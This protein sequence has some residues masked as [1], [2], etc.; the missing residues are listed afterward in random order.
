MSIGCW[1]VE[2]RP[3]QHLKSGFISST[4]FGPSLLRIGLDA[5]AK[6]VE[7]LAAEKHHCV[8]DFDDLISQSCGEW[9]YV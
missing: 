9:R 6:I 1:Q 8:E 3:V 7:A 5:E 2:Q 4:A